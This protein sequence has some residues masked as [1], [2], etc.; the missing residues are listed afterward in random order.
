MRITGADIYAVRFARWHLSQA[1]AYRQAWCLVI[2]AGDGALA[3][4]MIRAHMRH[5]ARE[6]IAEARRTKAMHAR[7]NSEIGEMP[8][9]VRRAITTAQIRA[10]RG[11]VSVA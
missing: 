8:G 9:D 3:A 1:K 4:G 11:F 7:P 5:H 6:A 10:L 2:A